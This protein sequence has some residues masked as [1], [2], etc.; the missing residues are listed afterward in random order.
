MEWHVH[1]PQHPLLKPYIQCFWFI[2]A[3][4][5]HQREKILPT[6]MTEIILNFGDAFRLWDRTDATQFSLHHEAWLVGLHTHYLLNEPLGRSQM[7]GIRFHAGGIH[8]F[9]PYDAHELHNQVIPM[10]AIWGESIRLLREA[11]Y[12]A[13][14]MPE[15]LRLL[16]NFLL[17]RLHHNQDA[18]YIHQTVQTL[19]TAQGATSIKGLAIQI[20]ISQKHLAHRFKQV[21]GVTPKTLARL[22]RFQ[23]V[24][25]SI[26]PHHNVDWADIAHECHYHD[27][28]HFSKDFMAFTGFSP[29]QYL[30]LMKPYLH[31]NE[32]ESTH[33]V[34][35][36]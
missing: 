7:V 13:R 33:F 3:F 30:H 18:L 29:S 25:S 22:Y 6:G 9:I 31:T 16:E 12:T 23:A 8:P 11:L 17:A 35:L 26:K 24:L 10:D 20:G 14:T 21:V 4:V 19:A 1:Q 2:D 32:L 5:P 34:P 36:G 15:R 27:Q 28:A